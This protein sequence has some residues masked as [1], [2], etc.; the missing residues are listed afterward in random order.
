MKDNETSMSDVIDQ[1]ITAFWRINRYLRAGSL[2]QHGQQITRVQ[3]MILRYLKRTPSCTI[4]QLA[5]HMNVRSSTMSQM[6]DRLERERWI[7]RN[8]A[9]DDSRVRIIELTNEGNKLIQAIELIWHERLAQPMETL[10]QEEQA[11]LIELL[12]KLAHAT[13]NSGAP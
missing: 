8:S 3:W 5:Q 7:C 2:E 6:L 10:S 11:Q 4:G 12:L 1:F 9:P 13:T